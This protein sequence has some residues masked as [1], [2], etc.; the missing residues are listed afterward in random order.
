MKRYQIATITL[1][2]AVSAL[3]VDAAPRK[4]ICENFTATWCTYCPDVANGLIL[5]MEEY[6]DTCFSM[7][8]HQQDNYSTSWGDLRNNF[9]SVTGYPTVWI[10]GVSSQVGSYGSGSANYAQL[11]TKY[12]QRIA[13]PTDVTIEMCGDSVDSNTYSVSAIVGIEN[14][15]SGKTMKIHCAQILHNY[16]A[17]PSHNYGCFKQASLQTIS[18]TASESQ[19]VSFTFDLDSSSQSNPGNV[20]YIAWAQATNN[21]GPAEVYQAAKHVHNGGDCQIDDYIVGAKGD[22]A[23]ISEALAAAGTGDSITV[24]PGTYY[25]NIDFEGINIVVES[26]NGP[27]VTIIDANGHGSVV[28]MYAQESST[29]RGFTLQNGASAIGAGVICNGSPVIENCIIKN[30][31]AQIGAGIYHF[32]NGTAGPT[33]SGTHFCSNKGSDIHGAWIDDGGNTFD[34]SCDGNSC[35][36]DITG[37]AVVN[38]SDLLAVIEAWGGSSGPADINQDGIVN[39][40]DLLEVVGSWGDC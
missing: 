7:Q 27:D 39:V 25:E 29:L 8:L 17:S 6:P 23:T 13:T 30:N 11:R 9:Y 36:A 2:L 32:E 1:A 24:M 16:P 5:L 18:L 26:M 20:S 14:G 35:P 31:V 21:S 22:F 15:G 19:E 12:L 34:E 3:S 4:V 38:V 33:V 10:D 40:V 37:D 28:K